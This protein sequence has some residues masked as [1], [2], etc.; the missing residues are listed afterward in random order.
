MIK[1]FLIRSWQENQGPWLLGFAGLVLAIG[2]FAIYWKQVT[3]VQPTSIRYAPKPGIAPVPLLIEV[4]GFKNDQG[5]CMIA[6]YDDALRF[7]D[8]NKA[9]YK[10]STKIIDGK[11]KWEIPDIAPGV[12]AVSVYHDE[13]SNGE[14]DKTLGVPTE[15]YGFSGQ[16]GR[17]LGPPKFTQVQFTWDGLSVKPLALEVK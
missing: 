13:N 12:L 15:P 5:V 14:L 7:L 16:S 8:I 3:H 4:S 11:A 17:L 1:R 9:I 10:G 6:I 2:F